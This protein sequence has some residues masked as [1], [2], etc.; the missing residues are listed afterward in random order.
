MRTIATASAAERDRTGGGAARKSRL[1]LSL[2]M[3]S[4]LTAVAAVHAHPASAQATAQQASYDIPAQPLSRALVRFSNATGL[5]LFYD[6]TLVRGRTSPGVSGSMSRQE[7]LSRLLAGT[8]LSYS[9]TNNNT[10]TISD[11]VAAAHDAPVEAD[12]SLVLDTINVTGG[13]GESS[14]YTPYETAAPTAHIS[15][16]NIDRF[17][18]SSPADVF[19]GTPGVMSGE[20]RNGA[21]SV[22]VN[23]R[24]MQ[25]FGRVTTTIDGAENAVTVYQGYQGVSNRTF[26]DPDFIAGIDVTK[27][28]DAA[29]WGNA[30]AVAMRTVSADDIVKPGDRW[31]IRVKGGVGGNTSSPEAGDIAGYRYQSGVGTATP[32]ETGMDRPSFLSPTN[33]SGSVVGAYKGD[34]IDVLAGYARRSQGNYHAG[35]HGPV[36]EPLN[37]GDTTTSWGSTIHNTMINNGIVNY[38]GGEEVL[39]TQLDTESWLAKL[40]AR[41]D[42]DQTLQI[43][44]T[45]YRSEAG[46]RLASRLT[47]KTGQAMQQE[48]TA[49]TSLD[50]F[51]ARYRWNPED[52]DLVDLKSNFYWSH[53]KLRNPIRGG[54]GVTPEDLG[55]PS[56]FRT[57][58]DSDLWGGDVTNQ[59]KFSLDYGDLDLTYG[60][61]YRGEDTRG[62]RHTAALEAWNT[63]RDAIR[64]EVAG[65]AKAAW[66]PVD[67]ATL[68]AGLRY[69]H[70]WSKDRV[71]PYERSQV[72]NDRVV[73]GF[74]T[75]DGGLS[76]SV[77]VTLEPFDGTQFYVNYSNVMR[78][79]SIIES[80]S[81]FNSVVAQAGV[82]PERSSNWEVGTNLQREGLLADDDRA[83]LKL[84]YFNW[85]VKDYLARTVVTEPTITL[86]IGN[87]HRA[88]FSGLELAGRYE[89]GG[90]TMDLA[91]NYFLDVE[92]CRTADTCGDKT[93]Y[94]DYATNHVQP[95]YSV[96]L[97][98]S[99]KLFEDRLTVGGRV[100][101]VGPRAIGHGDVTAQGASQFI[102]MVDWEPYTLVDVFAEYKINDNLTAAFRVE[103]LFDRF[104]VDPLALVTQPGPGRAFYVSLT[105]TLGGEQALPSL[106]S[107]FGGSVASTPGAVDWTGLYAG[108][109]AG[110]NFGRTWGTTTTLDGSDSAAAAR[111]SA[112]LGLSGGLFGVQAGY[113]WQL[114]NRLVLGLEADWSKTYIQDAKKVLSTDPA[115]AE[116]GHVDAY[117]SYDIDWTASLRPRIGYVLSD[118]LMAYATGGLALARETQWRDQYVSNQ[119]SESQPLGN[120]TAVMFVEKASLTRAG[121][122]IG[123]GLEYALGDNWSIRADYTYSR[124][125][126]KDFKFPEARA[127]T[128]Q[129]Y[130][131]AE[132]VGSELVD[133]GYADDPN[134]S[135]IC[136]MYP[137][138]CLPY[139]QPIYE[140]TDHTGGSNI[141]TG[142]NASNALDFHAFKIGLNYRF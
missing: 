48:Q 34:T 135:W 22:D 16:E 57:G 140:Y 21:G 12:G 117:T 25:G 52:N 105:G 43:G 101:H 40:T 36:A 70:F 1:V 127:G 120:E 75:S 44:Y 90:L 49:G 33:G 114:G 122:M 71:D 131:S 142:R 64:H 81:A 119:A 58:S 72:D 26:V 82:K 15:E 91:A 41:L 106:P 136:D 97:T 24:G 112:D 2:L 7:A 5:Q 98:L 38:R 130:T 73:P 62:S 69:S 141:V 17:R 23:I 53:L 86:N 133:P 28:A 63:P 13:G 8:G 134:M 100:S 42:D 96:D 94:G 18:G 125:A 132:Q 126:K 67:W 27:G 84:G 59:S 123:G 80:V 56:D 116:D 128:G 74:T 10:V 45:G 19:R 11:R 35:K 109:H 31:G 60:L 20:A 47:G 4:A 110:G 37:I 61:S 107:P 92:Y 129:D 88:K 111:E 50:T 6:A 83:M 65:F 77:G 113:N 118:R 32:S 68:N 46:D 104:Y 137:D 85:D 99:Q 139:E 93:L 89:V 14:D 39:N 9:F 87:I 30:G 121:F 108:V 79:P 102:A 103:N 55:L 76:P 115:L 124:F 78:A 95:K 138:A 3:T 29:S 51:T 54:R 66:K